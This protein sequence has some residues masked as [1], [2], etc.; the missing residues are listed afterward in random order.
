MAIPKLTGY[1]LPSA[2]DI[3]DNKVQWAFEP[4]RAALHP[5]SHARGTAAASLVGSVDLVVDG[6][7]AGTVASTV[8]DASGPT[9]RDTWYP[10]YKATR[11]SMPDDLRSQI[12][13]IHEVVRLMGWPVLDVPGE[14]DLA[15][16]CVPADQVLR[17]A[18][19]CAYK[20]VQGLVVL[21]SGFADRDEAG[22]AAELELV[23]Y[24]RRHG[25]RIIGPNSIEPH[26]VSIR[27]AAFDT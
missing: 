21:S 7:P 22:E 9:F 12:A 11:A 20:R 19:E 14:L 4:D 23:T 26:S 16:V 6:G 10:E 3:P 17:V 1:A 13:P 27:P 2:N 15:I 18:E 8:V 25:M 5:A 24:A